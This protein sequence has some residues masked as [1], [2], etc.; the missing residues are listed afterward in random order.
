MNIVLLGYMGSGKTTLAKQLAQSFGWSFFDLD[1]E[2]ERATQSSISE[3]ILNKGELYFRKLE[4]EQLEGLL[5]NQNF[6]LSLGGGTPC[7]YDNMELVN[8]KAVSIFLDRSIPDLFHTLKEQRV[9]RPLIAHL[10]EA[11]LKEFIAKHLFER[12]S[13]YEQAIFKT[14]PSTPQDQLLDEIKSFIS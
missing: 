14:K 4:R 2:I 3:L 5:E 1:Q 6:V 10:A 12:R 7:Y 13:F 8:A 9:D 11:D